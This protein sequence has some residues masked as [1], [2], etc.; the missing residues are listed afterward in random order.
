MLLL[1]SFISSLNISILYFVSDNY[2]ITWLIYGLMPVVVCFLLCLNHEPGFL[3]LICEN[4]LK[5]G[6][7]CGVLL[8]LNSWGHYQPGICWSENFSLHYFVYMNS[9]KSAG[10]V[11]LWL[12]IFRED[13][14]CFVSFLYPESRAR[15]ASIPTVSYPLRMLPLRK[16]WLYGRITDW[17]I[18][19]FMGSQISSPAWVDSFIN[20]LFTQMCKREKL[21]KN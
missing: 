14:N 21:E 1:P 18:L 6:F 7:Q 11:G 8:L 4:S 2:S 13:F 5:P 15:Q 9:V 3:E 12:G 16:T 19:P 17:F 10:L 20:F